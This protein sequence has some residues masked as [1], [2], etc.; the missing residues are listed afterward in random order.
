MLAASLGCTPI[1]V[2]VEAAAGIAEGGKT[3]LT[4]IVTGVLFFISVFFAPLFAS[5]PAIATA[6]VLMLIGTMMMSQAK[7]IDWDDMMEAIPVFLTI[8]MMPF[9][10][11]IANGIIFGLSSSLIIYMISGKMYS[12]YK[13]RF[14]DYFLPEISSPKFYQSMILPTNL[15]LDLMS[16]S[17]FLKNSFS[18]SKLV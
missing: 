18:N 16:L 11:S 9:T 5:I 13:Q 15:S 17:N 6:P 10:F 4:A 7:K 3:G 12:D 2:Y 1:I 8:I 14:S